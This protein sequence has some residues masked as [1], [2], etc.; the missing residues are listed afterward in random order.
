MRT[1]L[2]TFVVTAPHAAGSATALWQSRTHS[3]A[4]RL[5]AARPQ[6]AANA[7]AT[8]LDALLAFA[9]R[10][11]RSEKKKMSAWRS[12]PTIHSHASAH[13]GRRR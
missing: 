8:Q 4:P 13:S 3:R 2:P 5:R 12:G 11:N 9:W 1:A 6:V 7:L 10:R